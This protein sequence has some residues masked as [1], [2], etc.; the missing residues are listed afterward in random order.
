[1]LTVEEFCAELKI[2]KDTFY[3]WRKVGTAPVCH[4]LPNGELRIA[5]ADRDT[6]LAGLREAA[7]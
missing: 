5:K 7:A 2:S 1:M 3:H 4:R 6:W